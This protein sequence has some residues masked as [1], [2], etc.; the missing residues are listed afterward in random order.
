MPALASD[1]PQPTPPPAALGDT[2]R[3]RLSAAA[4][5]TVWTRVTLIAIVGVAIALRVVAVARVPP[6]PFYD[7]AVR[8]MGGSWHAF[9]VGALEPGARVAVDKPPLD[10]WLQVASTQLFGFGRVSLQLPI[11][12]AG[13]AGVVLLYD[14]VRRIAGRGAGLAAALVLATLPIAVLTDRSDTMDGVMTT[15]LVLTAWLIVRA[16]QSRRPWLLWA[17][18]ATAGL[19]FEVKLFESLIAAPALAALALVA[20]RGPKRHLLGALATFVVVALVWIT[21][22]TLLPASQ[23]PYA[24]GSSNGTEWNVAISYNGLSRLKGLPARLDP[25]IGAHLTNP[26]PTRLL[27]SKTPALGELLGATTLAAVVLCVLA[28]AAVGWRSLRRDRTTAAAALALALWL[29]FGI[30]VY[31]GMQHLHARYLAGL[32]PAAAAGVGVGV[33][34]LARESTRRR[35]L[36]F[37][38]AGVAAGVGAFAATLVHQGGTLRVFVLAVLAAL[39]IVL[40]VGVA[41]R[42]VAWP[43]LAVASLLVIV[44]IPAARSVDVVRT[45]ANDAGQAGLMPPAIQ[46]RLSSY[47]IAHQGSASDEAAADSPY[48]AAALVV[49]DG[50]PVLVLDN[51]GTRPLVS[52]AQL[53]A[54]IQRGQVRYA[55]LAPVCLK[56]TY[57]GLPGCRVSHW[58]RAHGVNVTAEAGLPP[59]AGRTA[60]YRLSL[61]PAAA[62]R[63]R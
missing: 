55:L 13:V 40:A 61:R 14:L 46:R 36:A 44:A 56:A 30:V 21:A 24:L 43:L 51:E 28:L 7:A 49:H 19:A 18:G 42:R 60:L 47:L 6:D 23:R 2:A 10:L 34:V 58:V 54:A 5:A 48:T 9:L 29:L 41:L 37:A 11:I 33:V 53:R 57:R 45:A 3:M 22:M 32:A 4:D 52:I 12:I 1:P 20:W 31:S 62:S 16:A 8:T 39:A 35:W 26:G 15:L 38:C 59:G 50:R 27:G 25:Q 63:P 17:A